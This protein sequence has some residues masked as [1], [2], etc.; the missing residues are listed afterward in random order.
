M[1][2]AKTANFGISDAM[3]SAQVIRTIEQHWTEF[4]RLDG[5]ISE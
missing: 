3:E 4:Q 1:D 2:R 5:N